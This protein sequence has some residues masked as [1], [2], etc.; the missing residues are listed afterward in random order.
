[1]LLNDLPSIVTSVT[2]LVLLPLLFG[3]SVLYYLDYR[4]TRSFLDLTH[5]LVLG[6]IADPIAPEDEAFLKA[7]LAVD[8][9]WFPGDLVLV[10]D[11]VDPDQRVV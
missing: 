2:Q 8:Y 6:I 5:Y 11:D 9:G 4:S 1:M 10:L 3:A 7:P